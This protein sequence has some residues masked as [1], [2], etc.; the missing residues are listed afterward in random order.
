MIDSTSSFPLVVKRYSTLGGISLNALLSRILFFSSSLS[1][2]LLH[3]EVPIKMQI[4][5]F[6]NN[7]YLRSENPRYSLWRTWPTFNY[8][9][10]IFP[11]HNGP[12]MDLPQCLK[13]CVWVFISPVHVSICTQTGTRKYPLLTGLKVY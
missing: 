1:L 9:R 2:Y 6:L 3:R 10:W 8:F 12:I 11:L 5:Y 4:H 7:H 13:H